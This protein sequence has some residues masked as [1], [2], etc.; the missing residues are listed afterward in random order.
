MMRTDRICFPRGITLKSMSLGLSLACLWLTVVRAEE[1]P[2]LAPVERW[3]GRMGETQSVKA[4][5]VQQRYL[6]TLRKPLSTK[7]RLWLVYPDHF[8]WELG[9]PPTTIAIR[10]KERLTVI[11]PKK[12]SAQFFSLAA[13]EAADGSSAPASLQSVTQSF[14]RSMEELVEHFE[15]QDLVHKDDVYELILKPR[16]KS[17]TAMRQVVFYIDT[18]EYYLHAVELRFSDKSKVR[19][20]FTRLTF[21]HKIP[22]S[23]FQPDLEGFQIKE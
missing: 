11:E 14:P 3:L 4:D 22:S 5:F 18:A 2:D 23:T 6:R 16:D 12:K 10:D 21:N 20:S 19:T 17:L 9:E 15:I 13:K 8:R 7:G 1:K